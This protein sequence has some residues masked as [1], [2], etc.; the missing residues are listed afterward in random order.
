MNTLPFE[1]AGLS[2]S[3]LGMQCYTAQDESEL[4][5]QCYTAQDTERD[6]GRGP[7]WS[8]EDWRWLMDKAEDGTKPGAIAEEF[9]SSD[10]HQ[11]FM[12]T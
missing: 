9:T 8:A 11:V 10:Q 1:A 7:A 2:E 5:T 12:A 6:M 4:G 3:E